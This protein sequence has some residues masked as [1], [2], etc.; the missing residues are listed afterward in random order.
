MLCPGCRVRVGLALLTGLSGPGLLEGSTRAH[1]GS[2][3]SA[4]YMWKRGIANTIPE[5]ADQRRYRLRRGGRGGRPPG[6]DR[7]TTRWRNM[8]ERCFN[9]LK[10][11][12][13]IATRNEN[14]YFLRS[15]GPAAPGSPASAADVRTDRGRARPPCLAAAGTVRVSRPAVVLRRSGLGRPPCCRRGGL[16]RRLGRPG[17]SRPRDAVVA[18]CD[19]GGMSEL[20]GGLGRWA[21]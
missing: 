8:I 20:G 21:W 2:A 3:A 4:P 5:K 11:F 12:R 17:R 9:R 1:E 6:F 15:S 16:P 18:S 13:G 10:G 7:E 19:G 14:R